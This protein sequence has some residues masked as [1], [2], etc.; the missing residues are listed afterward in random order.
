MIDWHAHNINFVIV[1][2]AIVV[3]VLLA[4]VAATLMR[5]AALKKTLAEMKLPDPGHKDAT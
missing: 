2:Y 4:L 5:A 1:A 3:V